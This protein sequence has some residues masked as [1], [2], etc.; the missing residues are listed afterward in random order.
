MKKMGN[1]NI[2]LIESWATVLVG[3]VIISILL[4]CTASYLIYKCLN[5]PGIEDNTVGFNQQ[6]SLT[7]CRSCVVRGTRNRVVRFNDRENSEGAV[8]IV[9]L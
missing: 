8:S 4:I 5:S 2:S 7:R 6:N 9:T 1:D 3:F